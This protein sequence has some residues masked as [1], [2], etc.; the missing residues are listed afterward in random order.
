MSSRRVGVV[1]VARG[2]HHHLAAQVE[3]LRRQTRALDVY[4]VVAMDDP[5]V[6]DVARAGA[7]PGWDL[8]LPALACPDG[9]LPLAAA[10]NL[11]A[12]TATLAGADDLVFLDVDCVPAP[13]LVERYV[14]V[15]GSIPAAAGPAVLCGGVAYE[16]APSEQGALRS[17]PRHHPARPE[18]PVDAVE[19]GADATLF[20]SLSFA[21]STT[22]FH[23]VGGFDEGYVGYGAEDTDFG[24]RLVRAGG[25]L[26]MVGGAEAVHQYHGSADPPVGH[27]ADIVRN[28]NL[29]ADRWGWWPMEGWLEKFRSMDLAERGPDGRWRLGAG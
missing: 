1:T 12:A 10:R 5:G 27:L 22:D 29:F 28:A 9:R 8:R 13:G 15:L 19:D 3:G 6:H 7:A 25:R 21:V 4:V 2:R 20:W 16:Q 18:L 14:E 17:A 24:Q 23:E 26:S 11:G